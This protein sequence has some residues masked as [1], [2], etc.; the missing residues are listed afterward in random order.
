MITAIVRFR[1]RPGTTRE[2]AIDAFNSSAPRYRNLPGLVRKYY[3]FGDGQGGG[4]Y[5]WKSRADA[6]RLYTAEWRKGIAD[7]YGS[8]PEITYFESPVIV[9]NAGGEERVAAAE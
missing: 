9:D 3:L 1:L 2:S 5:L 4:V 8:E 6:E 7:R